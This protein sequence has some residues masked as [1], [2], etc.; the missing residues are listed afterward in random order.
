MSNLKIANQNKIDQLKKLREHIEDGR[1]FIEVNL[2]N[3]NI[4]DG[5]LGDLLK[6][7]STQEQLADKLHY[8]VEGYIIILE[9]QLKE[10]ELDMVISKAAKLIKP[11]TTNAS[12][13]HDILERIEAMIET[14]RD[15]EF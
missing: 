14:E 5:Y 15:W 3:N 11:Y 12:D 13:A 2:D 9:E 1:I 7:D 6:E 8:I 4:N 10:E